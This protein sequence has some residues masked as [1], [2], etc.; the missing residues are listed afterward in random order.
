[1]FGGLRRVI[2]NVF[3][4]VCLSLNLLSAAIPEKQSDGVVIPVHDGFLKIAVCSEDVFRIAYSGDRTFFDRKSLVIV[5]CPSAPGD[6]KLTT[7]SSEATIKTT[8]LALHVNLST[9]AVTFLDSAGKP[10]LA[11]ESAGR[12]IVP[13]EVQG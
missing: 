3:V 11:E 2:L 13:A 1:M 9:G 8:K 4:I 12:S 7:T 10:I 5:G 6:W